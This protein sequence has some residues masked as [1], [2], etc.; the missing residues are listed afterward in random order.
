MSNQPTVGSSSPDPLRIQALDLFDRCL[1]QGDPTPIIAFIERQVYLQPPD[2]D[3]FRDFSD[4]LQQRIVSLRSSLY[5]LR[6]KLVMNCA[7]HQ[8]DITLLLPAEALSEMHAAEPARIVDLV[9]DRRPELSADV[10]QS[11]R[12]Q[13]EET[14]STA[15]QIHGDTEVTEMMYYL[16]LDWFDALCAAA[17]RHEWWNDFPPLGDLLQ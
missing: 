16:V 13:I 4:D 9:R 11:L 6:D 2:L 1:A 8:I 17:S 7:S 12:L 5:E 15:T 14:I 10:Q 3:L